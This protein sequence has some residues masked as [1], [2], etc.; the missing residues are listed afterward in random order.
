M[1]KTINLL[2]LFLFLSGI[3]LQPAYSFEKS[4]Q[5]IQLRMQT[6]ILNT[7]INEVIPLFEEQLGKMDLV[8]LQQQL[9]TGPGQEEIQ[10]SLDSM[11]D[12]H[13]LVIFSKLPMGDVFFLLG[14]PKMNM[15]KYNIGNPYT[16]MELAKLNPVA[17]LFVP[18]VVTIY[19]DAEQTTIQY[20]LPSSLLEQ[21][22]GS[23]H[24]TGIELDRELEKIISL[25]AAIEV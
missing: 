5:E 20:I 4:Q 18:F 24:E 7:G 22:D 2:T 16:A 17:S 13:T 10:S 9:Q 12:D 8:T 23:V 25:L 3:C 19:G 11:I 14:G 6:F 21:I 1:F 15:V